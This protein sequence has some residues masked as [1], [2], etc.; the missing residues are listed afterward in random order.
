VTLC[1]SALFAPQRL[2]RRLVYI[3]CKSPSEAHNHPCTESR[4]SDRDCRP[5]GPRE[6]PAA[7]TP[8]DG[9]HVD[10]SYVSRRDTRPPRVG[11]HMETVDPLTP[12]FARIIAGKER[13]R[14]QLAAL[15]FRQGPTGGATAA[16]GGTPFTSP[17]T[18]RPGCGRWTPGRP[19]L[20]DDGG[21]CGL[22]LSLS[23]PPR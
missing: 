5:D 14:Q 10:R 6:G 15:P 22:P 7:G 19:S 3:R 21:C 1:L 9:A 12:E 16:D 2:L 20:G 13:R 11:G 4:S 23:R 18:P 8:A 17:R